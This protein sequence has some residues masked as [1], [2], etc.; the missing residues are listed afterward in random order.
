MATH[1]EIKWKRWDKTE[2]NKAWGTIWNIQSIDFLGAIGSWTILKGATGVRPIATLN[3]A[4]LTLATDA[5]N[6]TM[7][8]DIGKE[9]KFRMERPN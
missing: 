5:L 6:Y 7:Q 3:V 1:F 2:D 9:L 4:E 8:K